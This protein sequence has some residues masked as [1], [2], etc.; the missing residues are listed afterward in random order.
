MYHLH[1]F[2]TRKKK[3]SKVSQVQASSR[4]PSSALHS[5]LVSFFVDTNFP[6]IKSFFSIS[7]SYF[8]SFLSYGNSI[9]DQLS[10]YKTFMCFYFFCWF[11]FSIFTLVFIISFFYILSYL[12]SFLLSLYRFYNIYPFSRH[13]IFN[14]LPL[15]LTILHCILCCLHQFFTS[16]NILNATFLS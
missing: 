14:V 12:L 3:F 10:L 15:R 16:A 7:F 13:F 9:K 2:T 4:S 6:L 8:L 5:F 11:E 1:I